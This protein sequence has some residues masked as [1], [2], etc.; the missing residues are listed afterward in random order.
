MSQSALDLEPQSVNLCQWHREV[1][2]LPSFCGRVR[3]AVVACRG[4]DGLSC[5]RIVLVPKYLRPPSHATATAVST[6]RTT[7]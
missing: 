7:R 5:L 2:Y 4:M 1:A 6:R 3:G